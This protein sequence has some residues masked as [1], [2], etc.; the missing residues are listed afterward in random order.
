[1]TILLTVN[2]ID[3]NKNKSVLCKLHIYLTPIH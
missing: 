2:T 1:M 3:K